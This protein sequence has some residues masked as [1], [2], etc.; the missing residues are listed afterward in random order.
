MSC[1]LSNYCTICISFLTWSS[2]ISWRRLRDIFLWRVPHQTIQIKDPFFLLTYI[3]YTHWSLLFSDYIRH[4]VQLFKFFV[5][6]KF[7]IFSRFHLYTDRFTIFFFRK[8][9][10]CCLSPHFTSVHYLWRDLSAVW[11]YLMFIDIVLDF[12]RLYFIP[13]SS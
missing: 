9:A 5:F 3:S 10:V 4:L 2:Y 11:L 6:S 1:I 13:Y 8:S 12:N 7:S